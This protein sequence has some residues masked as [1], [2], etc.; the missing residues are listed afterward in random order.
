MPEAE[1]SKEEIAADSRY[2]WMVGAFQQLYNELDSASDPQVLTM[3][4]VEGDE[5]ISCAVQKGREGV[6]R[7][8]VTDIEALQKVADV[9][10]VNLST[11]DI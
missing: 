3:L 1:K 7:V 10:T 4:V 11:E 6:L 2:H 5:L 8:A 9:S